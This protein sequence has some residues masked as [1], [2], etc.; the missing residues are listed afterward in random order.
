MRFITVSV[1]EKEMQL[2]KNAMM[3]NLIVFGEIVIR[4]GEVIINSIETSLPSGYLS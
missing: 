2:E 3:Q 4:R 1:R